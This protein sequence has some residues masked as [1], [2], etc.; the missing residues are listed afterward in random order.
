MWLD[1]Y[2][3]YGYNN[4]DARVSVHFL[5]YTDPIDF[6]IHLH[7]CLSAFQ[8]RFIL[9][10][11]YH[12]NWDGTYLPVLQLI[13][14]WH[15]IRHYAHKHC[16]HN[17]VFSK[18]DY[19][20]GK[21]KLAKVLWTLFMSILFRQFLHRN[22]HSVVQWSHR[23]NKKT[24]LFRFLHHWFQQ[25]L[26]LGMVAFNN[27]PIHIFHL[28]SM[29]GFRGSLM[30]EQRLWTQKDNQPEMTWYCFHDDDK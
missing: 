4:K 2:I 23:G 5:C 20:Y 26:C 21:R 10:T 29:L 27:T 1:P 30:F 11:P 12:C 18:K 25:G 14:H 17:Y 9:S 7:F 24:W 16:R 22:I 28:K 19:G 13:F 8:S 3:E 15:T 6:L